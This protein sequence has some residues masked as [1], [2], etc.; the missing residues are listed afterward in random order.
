MT[1]TD[2][3]TS[4]GQLKYI[5]T[6][7]IVEV[8]QDIIN[9]YRKLIPKYYYVKPQMYKAHISVVR[10]EKVPNSKFWEKYEGKLIDFYY[11][12]KVYNSE[13]Y[14]WLNCFS[15]ELE[16]IREELGLPINEIY[17]QPIEGFKKTFHCTLGNTK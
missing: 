10:K 16:D 15:K 9:F 14:W 1:G 7:L 4:S 5:H 13:T 12:N 17:I 2:V 11:L 3:F 6:K 8:D